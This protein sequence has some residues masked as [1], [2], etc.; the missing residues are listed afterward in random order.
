MIRVV[1]GPT[2]ASSETLIMATLTTIARHGITLP[3]EQIAK[4]C[5][6]LEVVELAVFG[7]FLRDD[8]GPE[9]DIDFLAVFKNGDLG[10]WMGKRQL[11][12]TLLSA[13][14]GGKSMSSPDGG[15]R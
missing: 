15:L 5:R 7:S 9:S 11:L 13:L 6:D 3:T 2:A 10:P 8:F 1:V 14:L 4:L 12:E